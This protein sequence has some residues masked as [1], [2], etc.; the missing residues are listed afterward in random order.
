MLKK[1]H[2]V[3]ILVLA[4]LAVLPLWAQGAAQAQPA[5]CRTFGDTGR[6]VC[7]LFLRYWQ[8]HGGLAQQGLPLS[9]ELDEISPVDGKSYRV[10]YFERAVFEHHPE[11]AGSPYEVLLSLLGSEQYRRKYATAAPVQH[12]NPA[13][14]RIFPATGK[15]LGGA[16]R[17]YWESHGGLAQQGYPISN[18]FTEQS[19]LDGQTYTVQYFER[20]V[21]EA[22]PQNR[23]PY[24]ILLSQ[25]GTFQWRRVHPSGDIWATLRARAL[26][27]PTI[28]PGAVCPATG[29][30]IVHAAYGPALGPGPFYPVGLG[31]SGDLDYTGAVFP[32][33]WTG[34][35]V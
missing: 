2:P 32:G 21:F 23:P 8:D 22:H 1:T 11:N 31:T 3:A 33:P 29:G 14:S 5:T 25:L 34:Q 13:N 17:A 15:T 4:G 7:G 18:E 26:R 20:A 10:Q 35:K 28:A 9:D 12:A 6:Q 30:T 24:D 27:V 19:E 16:F